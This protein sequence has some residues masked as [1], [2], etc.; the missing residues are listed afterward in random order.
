MS[1]VVTMMPFWLYPGTWIRKIPDEDGLTNIDECEYGTDPNNPDTDGDG[2]T[3]GWE[4]QYG[5]GS[6]QG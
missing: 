3:D 1:L 4:V 5:S 2:M 6:A